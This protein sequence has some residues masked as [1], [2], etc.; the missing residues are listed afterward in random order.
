MRA[1]EPG[2]SMGQVRVYILRLLH[3][4]LRLAGALLA[5]TSSLPRRIRL[6]QRGRIDV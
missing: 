2:T 4:V 3:Q 1:G 5:K 6:E